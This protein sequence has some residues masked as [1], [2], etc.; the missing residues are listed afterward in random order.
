MDSLRQL[1]THKC[2]QAGQSLDFSIKKGDVEGRVIVKAEGLKEEEVDVEVLDWGKL[3]TGVELK[4]RGDGHIFA[5][6]KV[7]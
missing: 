2:Y 6:E 3:E 5:V 4:V 1:I 7:S